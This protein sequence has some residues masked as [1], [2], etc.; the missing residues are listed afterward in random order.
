MVKRAGDSQMHET[1]DKRLF[2]IEERLP[3][4]P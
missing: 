3:V 1:L 4:A 2:V